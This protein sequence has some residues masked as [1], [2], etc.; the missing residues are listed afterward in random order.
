LAAPPALVLIES[1]PKITGLTFDRGD[2]R[3]TVSGEVGLSYA[4]EASSDLV[5][6]TKVAMRDNTTGSV[7]FADQPTTNTI[8]FY[9]AVRLAN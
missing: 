6:W 8:R 2:I 4:L 9:R 1:P 3:V 5:H 7:V